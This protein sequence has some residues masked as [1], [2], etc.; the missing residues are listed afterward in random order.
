MTPS[1]IAPVTQQRLTGIGSGRGLNLARQLANS[2]EGTVWETSLPGFLA[3]LY[4]QPT[5]ERQQKLE[6]MIAHPPQDPMLK[7]KHIS[8]AWP[9]DLLQDT[10]GKFV[11]FLM[12]TIHNGVKLSSIY[13]P[14]LRR[15]KAPGFN[16][17]YLHTAALNI[18]SV[19]ESIHARDYVVG[20]IKPQNLLVNDRALVSVIDT[21][22]FQ[23]R[24]PLNQKIYR[25]LVGSE[26]FTPVE[27][28]GQD[29]ASL[30]QSD[31]QDRFRL[32]VLV[33]LLLFGDHPFK[34]KWIGPGEAPSPTE[35]IRRGF[36]PYAQ[37]SLIQAGPNTIP[38]RVVHPGLQ[39]CFQRCFSDGHTQP[40][41]RPSAAE[42]CQSLKA[43]IATLKPCSQHPNHFYNHLFGPCY[44]CDRQKKLGL[45]IFDPTP[46]K[47]AAAAKTKRQISHHSHRSSHQLAPV[48]SAAAIAPP[49]LFLRQPF[50]LRYRRE[51]AAVGAIGL[52]LLCLVLLLSSESLSIFFTHPEGRAGPLTT[53]S[54]SGRTPTAVYAP[55]ESRSEISGIALS[56]NGKTLVTGNQD[57]KIRIWNTQTG[58]LAQ[59]LFGQNNPAVA[60]AF[61]PN[62]QNLFSI[63]AKAE[64]LQWQVK[65]G[66]LLS[67]FGDVSP[68]SSDYNTM[69]AISPDVSLLA[70]SVRGQ[71]MVLRTLPQG[72]SLPELDDASEPEQPLG[73]SPDNKLLLSTTPTAKIQLWNLHT[74]ILIRSFY[75]DPGLTAPQ[76]SR[77]LA[78]APDSKTLINASGRQGITLEN[79]YTG[80][81]L[82]SLPHAG[83]IITA[84]AV[85][86][87]GQTLVSGDREGQIKIWDFPGRRLVQ[88]LNGQGGQVIEIA[89]SQGDRILATT[90]RDQRVRLWQLPSGQLLHT[91]P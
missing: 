9:L 67:S 8:Y 78:I 3:K 57:F 6:V 13:N 54:A 79:A 35:L 62:G 53:R 36:W 88:T 26:G 87:E 68:V 41:A 5:L 44:W 15:R 1:P 66:H 34:G 32:G 51:L 60:L 24:D 50:Q 19:I 25:C 40:Q 59:T 43:A 84:L 22:S 2:G 77:L 80:Q 45:D 64:A 42:W 12:P 52:S 4:H 29:L 14:R 20:D 46:P 74:R 70:S 31:V 85:S 49:I 18:A 55:L 11:G 65:S 33:Y 89:L 69:I 82:A 75:G 83:A 63:G 72:K 47:P 37:G 73:I 23:I 81:R 61:S 91:L 90:H 71:R 17:Y 7:V 27:L 86:K 76:L 10:Q 30:D 56:P 48:S 28:L 58:K 38:L 39:S 21:D 16:W